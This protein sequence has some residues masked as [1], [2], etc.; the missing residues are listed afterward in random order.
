M[1]FLVVIGLM[2]TLLA[3]VSMARQIQRTL[4][5]P[6]VF[7]RGDGDTIN[8][9]CFTFDTEGSGDMLLPSG[10]LAAESDDRDSRDTEHEKRLVRIKWMIL[11]RLIK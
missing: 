2:T 3:D 9:R 7:N 5:K 8:G 11:Y 4:P 10:P 1:L 6:Y